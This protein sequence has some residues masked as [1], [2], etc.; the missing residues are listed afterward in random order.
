[1]SSDSFHP[2][3]RV[4]FVQPR[5]QSVNLMREWEGEGE[6][7][8]DGGWEY[9][10]GGCVFVWA[11]SWAIYTTNCYRKENGKI[12]KT[13]ALERGPPQAP[14]SAFEWV[15]ITLISGWMDQRLSQTG[16]LSMD[17]YR[18]YTVLSLNGLPPMP[19]FLMGYWCPVLDTERYSRE[20]ERERER[21]SN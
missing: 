7:V 11:N 8:R 10:P 20:R 16:K 14:L 4:T 17:Q 21:S 12:G 1:M 13:N 6:R 15:N 18:S 3:G 9:W 5:R 19:C 2:P